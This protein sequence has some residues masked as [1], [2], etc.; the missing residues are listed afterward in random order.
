MP[1][2]EEWL[3]FTVARCA[4]KGAMSEGG[5]RIR[6]TARCGG[7]FRSLGQEDSMRR[8]PLLLSVVL[9]GLAGVLT[10]AQQGQ[11]AGATAGGPPPA[12]GRGGRGGG[13]QIQ[14]GEE[15]PPGMTMTRALRCTTP[16]FPEPSI[17]DYRPRTTLKVEEHKVPKAKYP[18]VDSHNHTTV[19]AGNIEQLIK[20]MDALNL[21]VLINLSGGN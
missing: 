3:S 15:C 7:L 12:Q 21:S 17:L 6:L 16:E 8:A 11:G 2:L 10:L 14:P 9:V 20:E 13:V 4:R 5:N 18:V 1:G 19:N